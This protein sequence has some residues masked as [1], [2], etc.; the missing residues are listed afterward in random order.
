MAVVDAVVP[1]H[2]A[3]L[4]KGNRI[5]LARAEFK[6]RVAAAR[7]E[8]EVEMLCAAVMDPSWAVETMTVAD[9]M[10]ARHRWGRTR[11]RRFIAATGF[12]ESKMLGDLTM[13]Q[14]LRVCAMLR[15]QN[16]PVEFHAPAPYRVPVY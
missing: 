5:R 15:G 4:E 6:R 16:V 13:R 11:M 10:M 12:G 8:E 3:A 14:R 2:M 9:L 1:Q 7:G